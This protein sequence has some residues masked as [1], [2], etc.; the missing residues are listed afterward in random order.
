MKKKTIGIL[1]GMGPLATVEL[2]RK[3]VVLTKAESDRE[4]IHILIDNYP[5]IPDRTAAILEGSDRPV[6]FLLEAAD[7]LVQAGADF[8]LIPCNTSHYYYDAVAAQLPI[9]VL[10]MLQITARRL[11]QEGV[12]KVGLLATD[13]TI[14][15]GVYAKAFAEQGIETLCPDPEGQRCV[16][17]MIYGQIKAGKPIHRQPVEE[18]MDALRA[19]GAQRIILG[20]TELPLAFSSHMAEDMVDP[21]HLMALEAIRYAGY[22]TVDG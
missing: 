18:V 14:Q 7:R 20:C 22:K 4:H 2:F 8:L 3:L 16:M 12:N 6:S 9:P 17:D 19:S 10:N 13:G 11:R 1:G 21:A 15:T 5:Q